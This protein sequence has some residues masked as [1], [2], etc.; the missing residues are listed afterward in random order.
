MTDDQNRLWQTVSQERADF[1]ESHIGKLPNDILKLVHLTGVWPGGGIYKLE[2]PNLG[3]GLWVYTTF[4]LSNPDMPTTVTVADSSVDNPQGRVASFDV[5]LAKKE[6]VPVYPG[7]PGYGYEMLVVTQ[8][9]ADWPLVFLQWAVDTELLYD[10]DILGRVEQYGGLTTED[11]AVGQGDYVNVLISKAASPIPSAMT[12]SNGEA[13]VLIATVIT[14]DEMVWSMS[15]SREALAAHLQNS[16]LGQISQLNRQSL[17]HPNAVDLSTIDSREAAEGLAQK[18][19]L[20]SVHIF[21]LEFGGKDAPENIVY[22]P[23]TAALKKRTIDNKIAVLVQQKKVKGCSIKPTY[24]GK[25][26]IPSTLSFELSGEAGFQETL[27]IW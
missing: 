15:N 22:M 16:E 24:K 27:E 14:D 13:T 12:L 25:S 1:I 4:G 6:N 2:A 23:K 20:R 9:P 17:F 19:L 18:G 26:F 21:P 8:G 3:Q 5:S 11:I 7:R 10:A